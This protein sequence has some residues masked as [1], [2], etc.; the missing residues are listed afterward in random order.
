MP[1]SPFSTPPT[2]SG[3]LTLQIGGDAGEPERLLLIA[4]PEGG[5]VRVREWTGAGWG[6]PPREREYA[7]AELL[8]VVA[9]AARA[10]RRLSEDPRRVRRWLAGDGA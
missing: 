3:E 4:R 1:D 10:R 6:G 9:G 2:S 5:R 7:V 8:A